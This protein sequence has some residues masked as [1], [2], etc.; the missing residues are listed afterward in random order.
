MFRSQYVNR[1]VNRLREVPEYLIVAAAGVFAPGLAICLRFDVLRK[2]NLS[3]IVFIDQ[4]P[5]I[6][7]KSML[8]ERFNKIL[9]CADLRKVFDGKI[10]VQTLTEAEI[11]VA[12]RQFHDNTEQAE[13]PT[14]Y[15]QSLEK[16]LDINPK[17][18][19]LV[20]FEKVNRL[21]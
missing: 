19:C 8:L 20:A 3:Y 7:T 14:V 4:K 18:D 16:A 21:P 12:I 9:N 1:T 15:L 5:V 10:E 2:H 17:S 13:F 6:L 11:R